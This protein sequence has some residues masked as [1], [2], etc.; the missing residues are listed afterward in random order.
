MLEKLKIQNF[1]GFRD[2]DVDRLGRINIFA[3]RNNTGKSTLLEAIFLLGGAGDPK[4]ALNS[5]IVRMKPGATPPKPVW[6]TLWTPLFSE[7]DTDA[8]ITLSGRTSSEGDMQL[9][10]ALKRSVSTKA[11]RSGD[12][13]ILRKEY[14][15]DQALEFTYLDSRVARIESEARETA[16]GV[17]F[18]RKETHVAFQGSIVQPGRDDLKTDAVELGRLRKR[19]LGHLLLEPLQQVY[20][21]VRAIEDNASSGTPMI[22]VDIGLPELVP[23][24]VMG[25][26]MTHLVRILLAAA[27]A[28]DGVVLI[29][30]I[31]NGLHHSILA[32]VWRVI[33]EAARRF[34]VQVF[35]TTHSFECVSA[36]HEALG[37]D[38][39]RLHRFEIVDGTSRCVT[40]SPAAINGVIR[41]NLEVR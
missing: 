9:T 5:H 8:A 23:L 36:A 31:E 3:G 28:Q 19:K 11:S 4:M 40:L 12:D 30:E 39:F 21:K 41:H 7:L 16:E 32:D 14:S 26:G 17:V 18:D 25:A 37:P 20:C 33:G 10:M 27:S 1:R 15:G 2:L 38:G 34:N 35:A 29:D 6:A 22:L 13:G 24:S